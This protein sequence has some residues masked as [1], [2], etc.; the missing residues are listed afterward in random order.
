MANTYTL[1]TS[2]RPK[3]LH[4]EMHNYSDN[5]K[6]PPVT[7][8]ADQSDGHEKRSKKERQINKLKLT[9]FEHCTIR[10]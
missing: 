4:L 10:H 7:I 5:A 6:S 8:S 1:N 2:V 9:L 3:M